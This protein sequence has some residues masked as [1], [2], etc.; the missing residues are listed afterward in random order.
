[1]Q[2]TSETTSLAS[3]ISLQDCL[4]LNDVCANGTI[5]F[6]CFLRKQ[7]FGRTGTEISPSDIKLI[8]EINRLYHSMSPEQR[9]D[10]YNKDN[11]SY[12]RST[13]EPIKAVD[14]DPVEVAEQFNAQTVDNVTE[15]VLSQF[16]RD[17]KQTF[18]AKEFDEAF[19]ALHTRDGERRFHPEDQPKWKEMTASSRARAKAAE[20]IVFR[21]QKND[22][23]I[24]F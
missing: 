21:K 12:G 1:M 8:Q 9:A 15:L 10:A 13:A 20:M 14:P 19:E 23:F 6:I 7:A 17:G 11:S 22:W 3:N 16:R 4:D 18:T 2:L 24:I 5:R